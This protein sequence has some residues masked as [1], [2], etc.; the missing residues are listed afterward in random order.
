[1]SWFDTCCASF[2]APDFD[3]EVFCDESLCLN[4]LVTR[5]AVVGGDDWDVAREVDLSEAE[6]LLCADGRVDEPG[7]A[8]ALVRATLLSAER[9][10]R[11]EPTGGDLR[12]GDAV[13]V[14][15]DT[16]VVPGVRT[17]AL[18]PGVVWVLDSACFGFAALRKGRCTDCGVLAFPVLE[19]VI[20]GD[21]VEGVPC[22][23]RDDEAGVFLFAWAFVVEAVVGR[24]RRSVSVV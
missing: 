17:A 11:L 21:C 15:L 3:A 22:T 4:V 7:D 19:D 9:G 13:R 18:S 12:T 24:E 2:D 23:C 6:A 1:M 20:A 8:V 5:A 16:P 14:L 10:V